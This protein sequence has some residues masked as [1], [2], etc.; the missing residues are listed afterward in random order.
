MQK[1]EDKFEKL[2]REPRRG[3]GFILSALDL[4]AGDGVYSRMMAEAGY[5]VQAVD[6]S[7]IKMGNLKDN[8]GTLPIATFT[9][10]VGRFDITPGTFQ[11]VIARNVFPFIAD[12]EIVKKVI[13]KVSNGLKSGGKFAFTLFG[14]K[15]DWVGNP[16]MSFFEHEE[17][18]PLLEDINLEI[19][20]RDEFIGEGY[21]MNRQI[22]NWHIHT[23]ITRKK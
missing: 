10:D 1:R 22:K 8:R 12:K 3:D 15:D 9:D 17:I 11:L 20:D 18:L 6:E 7:V 13:T 23:Y 14:P 16:K 2:I 19:V 4:G 5:H 21:T